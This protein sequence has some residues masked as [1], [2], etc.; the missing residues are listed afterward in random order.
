MTRN[1]HTA[2]Q[3]ALAFISFVMAAGPAFAGEQ[4]TPNIIDVSEADASEANATEMLNRSVEASLA[5]GKQAPLRV[6]RGEDELAL[7]IPTKEELVYEVNVAWGVIG[8]A[9]G[10]VTMSTGVEEYRRS[11]LVPSKSDDGRPQKTG[12][13]KAHAY[14]EHLF[15]TLDATL[16][17]RHQP[18]EWPQIVYRSTQVGSETRRRELLVG[19]K[20][21]KYQ[22]SY[23]RDTGA[24]APRGT[25]IWRDPEL[26]EVPASA[27]DMTSAVYLVRTFI[28]SGLKQT[29]FAVID[30]DELWDMRLSLGASTRQKTPAG[31]FDAIEVVLVALPYEGEE[32]RE[33]K[34]FEGLFGLHG[35]IHL[36][37]DRA[38]GV[39]VRI[40][41]EVP[42]GPLTLDVDITL[43]SFK[44]TPSTMRPVA[45]AGE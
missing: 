27:L 35:S 42:A 24:G 3:F 13:I 7:F 14:G 5:V 17:A 22:S 21:G 20:D 1:F 18:T 16:E 9:L 38:A 36:W 25:R 40:M 23:R 44:G 15:Y 26:R 39:P 2:T 45:P 32:T 19:I 4:V 12:W 33:K 10:S 29:D 43:M 30:K 8:T 11:L 28:A 41:G 37:V 6:D 31:I 34:K